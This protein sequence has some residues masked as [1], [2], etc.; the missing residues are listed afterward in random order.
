MAALIFIDDVVTEG[1]W[2]S[3]A[4]Y[5][6]CGLYRYVLGRSWAIPGQ[7]E[8]PMSI[9][10][11][12]P[13]TADATQNDPTI[14]RCIGFAQRLG[15]TGLLVRNLF[16]YRATDPKELYRLIREWEDGQHGLSPWGDQNHRVLQS[17]YLPL[18]EWAAWGAVPKRYDDHVQ[19]SRQF[20][21][22]RLWCLGLTQQQA[23]RH[24]LMLSY[25]TTP[26]A[27]MVHG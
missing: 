16:A 25:K 2:S 20:L 9:V 24:P 1:S 21:P 5:S 23:P 6:P 12:N 3:W 17:P 15:Y 11:L 13:S 22:K 26:V 7:A 27:Y 8:R 18:P 14:R 10:M 19:Y 4:L